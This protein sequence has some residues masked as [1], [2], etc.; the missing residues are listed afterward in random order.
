MVGGTLVKILLCHED[1]FMYTWDGKEVEVVAAGSF[2]MTI[3]YVH[4]FTKLFRTER[5]FRVMTSEFEEQNPHYD[6]RT[7]ETVGRGKS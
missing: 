3:Q 4:L 7:V 5:Y 2:K 6:P 1:L